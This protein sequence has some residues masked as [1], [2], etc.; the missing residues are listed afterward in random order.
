M[1]DL[2]SEGKILQCKLNMQGLSLRSVCGFYTTTRRIGR[3]GTQTRRGRDYSTSVPGTVGEM[4]IDNR[5]DTTVFGANFTA[6]SFTGQ[7][8]D[9]QAFHESLPTERDV[10]IASAATAYDDPETGDTIILEFNQ[11]L[12]FGPTMKHS[13]VNPNQ[14]RMH[15][16]DLCDDPFD[17][18]RG[19]RIKDDVSGLTVPLRFTKCV[20]G[21]TTRAP[22]YGE[23]EDAKKEGRYIEMTSE[24]TWDPTTVSI[25]S[26][27]TSNNKKFNRRLTEI[28]EGENLLQSCSAIYTEKAMLEIM[29]AKIRVLRRDGQEEEISGIDHDERKTQVKVNEVISNERHSKITAEELAR[30]WNIGIESAKATLKAT[31]QY[32][33]RH[34]VRPLTRRYRTDILQSRLRRLNCTM[35]TDT[36][37][38]S[39]KSLQG[40]TCGQVFTDGR[41]VYFEPMRSKGEA[42]NSL[43][44]LTQDIGVPDRL[45]FDGAKENLGPNT[46]FMKCIRKNHINWK[47]TEPYSHWQN[48]AESMIR[49]VRKD[50]RRTR[51]KRNVP[52]RL[53]DYGMAHV[54]KLRQFIARGPEW[55]TPYE[56]I[57]GDTPD[58]SEWVDFTFYDWVWYWDQPGDEDNPKIGRWLGVSHRIGAAMC[59]W[60]LTSNG[61]V[62]SRSTVQ[63]M[64][65]IDRHKEE[66]IQRMDRFTE[67]TSRI[68]SDHN[69]Q[70][71]AEGQDAFYIDDEDDDLEPA[72][73]WEEDADDY[74]NPD[75][76]DEYI[77]AKVMLPYGDTTIQGKVTKRLKGDDGRPIGT[78][79]DNWIKDTRKYEVE[80][81]DGTTQEFC[82]NVLA[83][84]MFSQVD[85]EGYE[86]E[87]L[88]EIVD[89]KKD[90][91]AVTKED[92]FITTKSN[93]QVRKRTTRGWKL[94]VQWKSGTSDWIPLAQLKESN[95]VEVAKYATANKIDDEPAFAWWVKDILRKRNRII[96]KV[97][98]RYWRTT[99]KFGIE[100]PKTVAEAYAIDKSTGTD[101]WRRAIEKEM[102]RI[103][104]MGAFE[105]Y[106]KATP[107]ELRSGRKKLPGFSEISCHM[108]FDIKMDGKFTRKARF[109]ANGNQTG[110]I[111]PAWT[112]SSVVSRES[113]RIAF[114]HAALN[115][116]DVLG[117][118]VS[119]AYLNA[120]CREK[121]WI[122]AG[123]EFGSEEGT[124]MLIRKALYGLKSAG[125]SWR[126]MLAESLEA[127]GWQ[128][129]IADPDVYRRAAVKK[130]GNLYYELLLVYVDDILV[131]SHEPGETMKR[132]GEIYDLRGSVG[133]PDR[134]L[135]AN[136]E[137]RQTKDGRI[138]WA[139]S[140]REYVLNAVKI[141][142]EML[143]EDGLAL[144]TGKLADRPMARSYH[145]ELDVTRE[146]DQEG[147]SR[148][149]QLIGMLRWAVELGR[150]D[151]LLE[152]SMLSSHLANPREGHLDAVYNIFAY[153]NK[154]PHPPIVLDDKIIRMN[155]EAFVKSDWSESIYGEAEEEIP[156]KAPK[157]LGNPVTITCFVD[158]NH[159]GE[160]STRRSQ[161][162]IIIY[163]NNAPIDWYSKRQNTVESSTFGSEFVAMRVAIEKIRAL[164]YKLRMFG[165]PIDGPTNILGDNE[166]V[167]NAASKVECRL[168]KKHNAICYHAVREACAA[169]WVRVGWEPSET[170]VADLFTKMLPIETRGRLLSSIFIRT[171]E[172]D[173]KAS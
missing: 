129:T 93:R 139:M 130:N 25:N 166:S 47:S 21:V 113:V 3:T 69:Q 33:V 63:R 59:Y 49:E 66:N 98:S 134:Y 61:T 79:N 102:A 103:R 136:I 128:N 30:K 8:C 76:F 104:G 56:E 122:K 72:T 169:G 37:F 92:G 17:K 68:L 96:A 38:G 23:I 46:E 1:A 167:V 78:R 118:D 55:R 158:A 88:Q 85:N 31:T 152:V 16:I 40:Y 143:A 110:D 90:G 58:I 125:K 87:L 64:T 161:T 148:Y 84:N 14:C 10:P 171:H 15:G 42:G 6:I 81:S 35:F 5:A 29:V 57:T 153:L 116:L 26:L 133:R 131:V 141:V 109:V 101:H 75:T 160:H 140:G 100:L 107:E 82:A 135:G 73:T 77:G 123:P 13:L 127:M 95:P 89:H 48:K 173:S 65:R 18:H 126:N 168:N 97:K 94:L 71:I 39:V 54:C 165:I 91:S 20:V 41:F 105:L 74:E 53:W 164:R 52:R 120:T 111:E 121:L 43:V 36:M 162:G 62:L 80:L 4:E 7:S 67:E 132:I 117:C 163:L 150:V 138:V 60:I 12:W 146:L 157:P 51:I 119:N 27:R 22:S 9:V 70:V 99:H 144:K 159:A 32:G 11:G 155:E 28:N 34:A 149:H 124:V 145:P 137:R 156:P 50:W 114:L 108:V 142:K 147:S 19:L 24:S 154:Q 170:N 45:V 172:I 112:Y 86:Y 83:E 44:N 106:D 151:I 115:D 2:G